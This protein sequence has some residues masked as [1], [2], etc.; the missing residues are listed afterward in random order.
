[1]HKAR[2]SIVALVLVCFFPSFLRRHFASIYYGGEGWTIISVTSV[3][4]EFRGCDYIRYKLKQFQ[5]PES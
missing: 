3:Q 2:V 4:G 1:M 5:R